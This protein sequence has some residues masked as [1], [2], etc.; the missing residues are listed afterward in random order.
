MARRPDFPDHALLRPGVLV[1]RRDDGHLQVGLD[2][3]LAMVTPDVPAT[4]TFLRELAAGTAPVL[5]PSVT[6][7]AAELLARGLIIDGAEL[8]GSLPC[9]T[10]GAHGTAAAYAHAG[11]GAAE[12][13]AR[14]AARSVQ[15]EAPG[16]PRELRG[17]PRQLLS[18]SGTPCEG[19][20]YAVLVVAVG[21]FDRDRVDELSRLDTPHLLLQVN[22]GIVS[23]GPFVVPGLT[24]C[25]RCVDAHRGETDPRRALVVEQYVGAAGSRADGVPQPIDPA[26]MTAALAW[27]VRDLVSFVDDEVPTTWSASVRFGPGMHQTQRAWE[28]HQRCGCSWAEPVASLGA[29]AVV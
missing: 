26:L 25:L 12:L 1:T 9:D 21:E 10:A 27:A 19:P 13:L 4:R 17:L 11:L 5:G 23:L 8:Q 22:E 6:R 18:A 2:P 3:S 7:L 16:L 29:T 20:P 28:R 24:A 14:R 15:V